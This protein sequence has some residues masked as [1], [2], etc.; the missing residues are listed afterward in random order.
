MSTPILE[1]TRTVPDF[2]KAGVLYYDLSTVFK[3]PVEFGNIIEAMVEPFLRKKIELVCAVEA[4]GFI[5]G[6]AIA[7][8]LGAGFVPIRK[9]NKL[10][11]KTLGMD[12]TLEYGDSRL[13]IHEDAISAGQKVL[14]VDDVLATGSTAASALALT[15]SLGADVL[16]I[17]FVLELQKLKG[18]EQLK[19]V[20]IFSLQ[21][22]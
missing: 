10:P 7:N 5:L 8:E 16:G 17:T 14:V 13:E 3:D 9:A 6:S 22:V 1:K 15:K 18:R 4:R 2:P 21:T 12:F 19:N 20:D 11:A